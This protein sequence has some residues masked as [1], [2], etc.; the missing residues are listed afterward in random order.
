[1]M[2]DTGVR[3]CYETATNCLLSIVLV[4]A[5]SDWHDCCDVSSVISDL[6]WDCSGHWELLLQSSSLCVS[7]CSCRS[8]RRS[9]WSLS[10]VSAGRVSNCLSK[11]LGD[12][13][14]ARMN[15]F[16]IRTACR[17]HR[18]ASGIFFN[19]LRLC[20]RIFVL[21]SLN[22]FTTTWQG[23]SMGSRSSNFLFIMSVCLRLSE[24]M[25][26]GCDSQA[27]CGV[28]WYNSWQVT[29]ALYLLYEFN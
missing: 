16:L 4:T 8:S 5:H 10:S 24:V 22:R 13:S 28:G 27:S 26:V 6:Y 21:F 25:A 7:I 20:F 17:R 9:A 11:C 1:M 23:S 14:F 12:K 3:V 19:F 18:S 29:E 2:R 15:V